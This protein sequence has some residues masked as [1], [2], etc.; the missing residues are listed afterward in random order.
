M[1]LSR[2]LEKDFY[3]TIADRGFLR[4]NREC[5]IVYSDFCVEVEICKVEIQWLC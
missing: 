2:N 1:I 5:I 3:K 4:Y